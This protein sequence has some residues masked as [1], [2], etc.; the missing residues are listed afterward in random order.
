MTESQRL[1][2]RMSQTRQQ[3]NDADI[4]EAD[5]E[6]L[7]VA[8]SDL[9][10]Q[11]RTALAAE[12]GQIDEDFSGGA[13]ESSEF[14]SL[15]QRATGGA[16][17]GAAFAAIA[18]GRNLAGGAVMAELQAHRGL[19]GH[20]LP[21]DVVMEH[22]AAITGLSG[23]PAQAQAFAPYVFP[24]R[25]AQFMGWG[26]PRVAYGTPSYPVVTTPV[27]LSTPGEGNDAAETTGVIAADA[28]TPQ[29]TQGSLRYS[30]EDAARFAGLGD[31]VRAHVSAAYASAVDQRCLTDTTS[32]LLSISEPIDPAS[33]TGFDDYIGTLI[34]D[35]QYSAVPGDVRMIIGAMTAAHAVAEY[36]TNNS[37]ISAY[38]SM[39]DLVGNDGLRVAHGI[40]APSANDQA[41]FSVGIVGGPHALAPL[42]DGLEVLVDPYT[43]SVKGEVTVTILGH[44]ALKI[45]RAGAYTRHRFQLA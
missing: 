30:R 33:E 4:S 31:A 32:G 24:S 14:R 27:Q 5:R 9:E 1:Q 28:L 37:P 11:Y 45:L 10:T 44:T 18:A 15:I 26:F 21:L 13:A 12:T 29:R 43:S 36:K 7:V 25:V 34:P 39:L 6:S 17:F 22:R 40:P 35:G 42:W 38:R 19:P 23:S 2:I 16:E 3:A 41:A 8:L 20:L